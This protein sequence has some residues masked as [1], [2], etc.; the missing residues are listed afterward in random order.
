MAQQKHHEIS[1]SSFEIRAFVYYMTQ[2]QNSH[3]FY[4]RDLL[5]KVNFRFGQ[6][7][8]ELLGRQTH[9]LRV[10]CYSLTAGEQSQP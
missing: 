8:T 2:L 7:S 3:S 4:F 10:S 6:E 1:H 5:C 9:A